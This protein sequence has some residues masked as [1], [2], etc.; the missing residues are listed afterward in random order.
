MRERANRV[1]VLLALLLATSSCTVQERAN[2]SGETPP[3]EV[4]GRQ[5]FQNMFAAARA[6]APD[7]RPF[8]LNNLYARQS[9][10]IGGRCITWIAGFASGARRQS[11][12]YTFTTVKNA[13]LKPGVFSGHDESY[14]SD[15]ELTGPPFEPAALR[16]DTDAAFRTAETN[17]GA[18]YRQNNTQQPMSF[19]LEWDRATN[20]VVWRVCYAP[21]CTSSRFTVTINASNGALLKVSR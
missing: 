9:P 16:T 10:G 8:R 4:T 21:E 12:T 3:R 11:R 7:A 19:V 13:G 6:W 5:A 1:F 18:A 17:G 15:S 20:L 14:R 2:I